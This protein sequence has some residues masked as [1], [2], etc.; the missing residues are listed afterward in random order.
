MEINGEIDLDSY[1]IGVVGAGSWGTALADL[2]AC[3]GFQ[4]RLWV[5]EKEVKEHIEQF[6]ENKLYLPGHQLSPNLLASNDLAEVVS[7][8]HLIVIVV[9]SHVM[10]NVTRQ[11]AG[12]LAAGTIIA[13]ASK[14]IEQ[15]SNKHYFST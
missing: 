13:S 9:P 7:D 11:M 1:R 3:K 8:K 10:R 12:H 4:I 2:L 5:F 15:K 14:G 6:H